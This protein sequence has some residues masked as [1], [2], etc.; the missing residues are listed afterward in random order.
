MS[1]KKYTIISTIVDDAPYG[2]I[3]WC[4]ISFLSPEKVDDTSFMNIMGFKVHNGF[5]T[6]ELAK[7]DAKERKI[8]DARYDVYPSQLG[9]LYPWDDATKTDE[10]EYDDAKLNE[11][12]RTRRE[13]IDKIKLIKEQFKN[14]YKTLYANTNLER[15]EQQRKRLRTK[16]YDKGLITK[17]EYENMEDLNSDSINRDSEAE[18]KKIEKMNNEL[19]ECFKTDYLDENPLTGLKFGCISIFTPKNTGGLKS[20]LFK[21]RGLFETHKDMEKRIKKLAVTHPHDRIYRFEIGKWCPY[22]DD[23]SMNPQLLLKQL[24]YAM[25]CYLD[26]SAKEKEN[27]DKRIK[28]LQERT[29]QESKIIKENNRKLKRKERRDKKKNKEVAAGEKQ[30]EPTKTDPVR[31]ES[32]GND[33]N[34]D[35]F[36]QLPVGNPEDHDAIQNIINF[37]DDPELRGKFAVD[38]SATETVTVDV[39]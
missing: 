5:N 28:T 33:A 29:E 35:V 23:D 39:N 24:N 32:T 13:N 19:D 15:M 31:I 16:L 3:N 26:N 25:K 27:F 10:I 36:S 37:L 34:S 9:K 4:T 18:T 2:D 8:K 21:I 7:N 6:F 30:T 11:L 20:V 14:E 1:N 12:D 22:T 38:K 17:D